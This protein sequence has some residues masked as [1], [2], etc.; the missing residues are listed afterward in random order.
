MGVKVERGHI[1][2]S[3]TDIIMMDYGRRLLIDIPGV[4]VISCG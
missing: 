3:M 2:Q 1:V 4:E